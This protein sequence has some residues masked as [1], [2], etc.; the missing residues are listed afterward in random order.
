MRRFLEIN[1]L[2]RVI[3]ESIEA[4][5]ESLV[6][7]ATQPTKTLPP[8][9]ICVQQPGGSRRHETGAALKIAADQSQSSGA[10]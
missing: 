9:A 5:R 6:I 7:A 3:K 1:R 4:A 2:E 10:K 8:Y